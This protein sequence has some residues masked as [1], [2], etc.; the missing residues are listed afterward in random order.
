M[1]KRLLITENV[2]VNRVSFFDE[3]RIDQKKHGCSVA[4]EVD[5]SSCGHG[6]GPGSQE[7]AGEKMFFGVL[8]GA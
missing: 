2:D 4:V 5:L 3:L 6:D 1:L 7:G 8:F